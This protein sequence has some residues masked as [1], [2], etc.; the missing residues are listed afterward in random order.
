[1]P[2]GGSRLSGNKE[3][4]VPSKVEGRDNQ[5]NRPI[6]KM[7][8]WGEFLEGASPLIAEDLRAARIQLGITSRMAAERANINP[9]LYLA[10]EEGSAGKNLENLDLLSLA[11]MRL[12]LE[13][14]RI[15]FVEEV[16][17][18]YLK[19]DLST[20]GPPTF[21]LDTLSLDIRELKE[22]SLFVSPHQVFHLG[23]RLRFDE[24]FES[25]RRADKQFVE[26]WIA[27]IFTLHLHPRRDYYVRLVKDN[28]PDVEVLDIDGSAGNMKI[29]RLEITQHGRYSKDLADVIG[30]KLRKKYGAGT[31]IVV[32]VEQAES[33]FI[34]ELDD[35]I[36]ANNP[37]NQRIVLIS[38]SK[39]PG[40]FV[41]VPWGVV[42]NTKPSETVLMEISV[43]AKNASKGYCGYKG[44]VFEPR[45]SR[46]LPPLSVFVKVIDLHRQT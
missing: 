41:I 36:R 12:G 26:L 35:F 46:F 21:F 11:A 1:M 27:A 39:T 31:I 23:D 14:L 43:D 25:K 20:D 10:L 18:Q 15:C 2:T 45:G 24:I 42:P 3:A 19:I 40:S 37:F 4:V 13:E 33:I 7:R 38:G 16:Q 29:H 6:E 44:V 28:A 30:K 22:Q 32:F 5:G 9:E 34:N 8:G 17:Q